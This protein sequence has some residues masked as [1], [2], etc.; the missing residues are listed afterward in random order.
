M[1]PPDRRD[2]SHTADESALHPDEQINP[3]TRR[4]QAFP[5]SSPP[6]GGVP[7]ARQPQL[8]EHD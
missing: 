4:S 8:G 3:F 6:R 2:Q 7:G 1:R 5:F